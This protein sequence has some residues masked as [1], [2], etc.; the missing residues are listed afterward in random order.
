MRWFIPVILTCTG[1]NLIIYWIKQHTRISH[2]WHES[3]FRSG[4]KRRLIIS[5]RPL[6]FKYNTLEVIIQLGH[7]VSTVWCCRV[8]ME[9]QREIKWP[10]R[11]SITRD[12]TISLDRWGISMNFNILYIFLCTLFARN[13]SSPRFNSTGRWGGQTFERNVFL[14][15]VAHRLN[16]LQEARKFQ[17]ILWSFCTRTCTKDRVKVSM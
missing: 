17:Q 1:V 5:Y 11:I 2:Y 7:D 16:L 6:S 4:T 14:P 13:V 15:R 12:F 3:S 9:Q 10:N 8:L